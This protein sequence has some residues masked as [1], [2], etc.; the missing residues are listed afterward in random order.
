MGG[1]I[2]ARAAEEMGAK[3]VKAEWVHERVSDGGTL[4]SIEA[5]NPSAKLRGCALWGLFGHPNALVAPARAVEP[6]TSSS[7]GRVARIVVELSRVMLMRPGPASVMEALLRALVTCDGHE[8]CEKTGVL[9]PAHG[10]EGRGVRAV[11][12]QEWWKKTG[13]GVGVRKEGG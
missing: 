2:D 3:L 6:P 11:T 13:S 5:P 9:G 10:R 8:P 4:V 1:S 12:S 7:E